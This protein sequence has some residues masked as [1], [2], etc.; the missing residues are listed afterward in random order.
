M[1][2]LRKDFTVP[3]DSLCTIITKWR[4]EKLGF[5]HNRRGIVL[6]SPTASVK[7]QRRRVSREGRCGAAAGRAR[8]EIV[9]AR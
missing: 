5:V 6:K 9:K 7:P 1:N 3:P 4:L 2:I 8:R